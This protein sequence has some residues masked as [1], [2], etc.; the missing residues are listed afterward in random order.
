M[1]DNFNFE[2]WWIPKYETDE[3]SIAWN[4]IYLIDNSTHGSAH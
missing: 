1:I 4:L 2:E 3:Y